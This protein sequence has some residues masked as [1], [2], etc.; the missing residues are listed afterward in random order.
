M[1]FSLLSTLATTTL[2][3]TSQLTQAS[4]VSEDVGQSTVTSAPV[5][6]K[7]EDG[8]FT[9]VDTPVFAYI[10]LI[11]TPASNEI[12]VPS[13][14]LSKTT[15]TTSTTSSSSS[16]TTSTTSTAFDG[17]N[18]FGKAIPTAIVYS[19]YEDSGACK[20]SD[21]ILSDLKIVQSVGIP[22][23]RMYGTDCNTINTVLDNAVLLGLKVNQGFWIG[24]DGYS[25]IT[26]YVDDLITWGQTNG[27]E[28]FDFITVGNEAIN[29][30][31]LTTAQLISII[32]DV[33]SRLR[34]GGYNGLVTTS[35]PPVTYENHPELCTGSAIDFAGINPHSYFDTYSSAA[36]SGTFVVGQYNIVKNICGAMDVFVTETGYPSAG[37]QNGG[38]IPSLANQEIAVEAILQDMNYNVTI[39]TLYN[40][41]WKDPGSYG[42]EQ[43]FG[44]LRLYEADS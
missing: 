44:T 9:A 18:S 2:L 13:S 5:V 17:F 40:D 28:I 34:A 26:G 27:W 12:P 39:L 31:Y 25:G 1:R 15:S 38:N 10:T 4:T 32:A 29:S 41:Y 42:I 36:T 23:I 22:S 35:E 21:T 33:K 14:L 7:R 19:P 11:G 6:L 43:S 20:S 30:G 16:S 8:L 37:I 24:P 3:L